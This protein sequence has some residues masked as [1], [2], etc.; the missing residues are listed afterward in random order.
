MSEHKH[1]NPTNAQTND[2]LESLLDEAL[3]PPTPPTDLA[4]RIADQ[5]SPTATAQRAS[6]SVIARLGDGPISLAAAAVL[7]LVMLTTWA[8]LPA[9]D[10]AREPDHDM[11]QLAQELASVASLTDDDATLLDQ[12]IDMLELQVE[13]TGSDP[14]WLSAADPID[15]AA[16]D[17]QTQQAMHEPMWMF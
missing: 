2:A 8:L 17:A 11:A 4:Q 12:R 5:T 13:M 14:M 6:R 10:A 1:D 15:A 16:L 9:P 7:A 3:A